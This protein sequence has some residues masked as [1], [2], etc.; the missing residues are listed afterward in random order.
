MPILK[1][2]NT[3]EAGNGFIYTPLNGLISFTK[4]EKPYN[5]SLKDAKIFEKKYSNQESLPSPKNNTVP[6]GYKIICTKE[7]GIIIFNGK[8]YLIKEGGK[9]L[10]TF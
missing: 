4:L 5:V 7:E 3:S 10:E 8:A 9:T 2:E 1:I 6:A